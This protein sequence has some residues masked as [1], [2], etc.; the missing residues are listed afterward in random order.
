MP[1]SQTTHCTY[2]DYL[3]WDTEQK[4]ELFDGTPVMQ[5]RPSIQHQN[6]EGALLQQLR[7]FLDGKPCRAFTEIE[8][9][10]PEHAHQNADD[11]STVYVPDLAV[12]CAPE[13]LHEQYCFGAPT[14]VMEILSPSTAKAD[15]FVKLNRYQ[16]AGVPEYWIISPQ[17]QNAT[18]FVLENGLYRTVA[19]YT[20]ED[21]A[22]KVFTLTG[23]ELDLTKV[24][25]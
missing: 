18:V 23:C 24:F 11:V 19:V 22:A 5:A 21:S 20:K 13:K 15:R 16:Q 3:T 9:L 12:I 8:V 10:L 2:A 14:V 7:N 4:Y 6:I 1:L 17:E 25:E